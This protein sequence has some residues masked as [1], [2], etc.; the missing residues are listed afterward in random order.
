[1]ASTL[2]LR[3]RGAFSNLSKQSAFSVS[4]RWTLTPCTRQSIRRMAT[5]QNKPPQHNNASR[6]TGG[7]IAHTREQV[8]WKDLTTPQKVVAATK[9]TT[10][11]AV[12]GAGL[13]LVGAIGYAIV[14]E[15]F[16]PSSDTAIFGDALDRLQELIGTPMKGHG[17]PSSS[18]RRRNRRISSQIVLD[19]EGKE[20][21]L[22]R[23]FVEGP[24]NEGTA[25]LEMIKDSRGKW[26]YKYLFV[27][28]PGGVRPAQR[29]FVEYNKF[30]GQPAVEDSK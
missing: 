2:G 21:L 9:T 3:A 12:I 7:A 13:V 20:H 16:G 28:I 5:D 6:T 30:A 1:M 23:F 29:I 18:K 15:L 4:S 26:E 10:N 11:F 22:M 27:D 17:D 14:S 24:D 8:Q 19:G 25:H